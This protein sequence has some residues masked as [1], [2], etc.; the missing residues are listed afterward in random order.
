MSIEQQATDRV[1]KARGELILARRFY[2]VLVSNVEPVLSRQFPTMATNGKKHFFNPEFVM[3]LSKNHLGVVTSPAVLL[4]GVQAHESE[5]DARHHGTRRN[6]RDPK[7][8]NVACDYAINIDLIDEGFQLPEGALIDEKY[9]DMSA[10]DIYRTRE[11]DEEKEQPQQPPPPEDNEGDEEGDDGQQQKPD[12]DDSKPGDDSDSDDKSDDEGDADDDSDSSDSDSDDDSSD[13]DADGDGD[14]DAED[15]DAEGEGE[16]EGDAE[17]GDG[18]GDGSGDADGDADADD[19]GTGAGSSGDPGQCGEV[20]DSEC[21]EETDLAQEDIKWERNVRQAASMAKAAGQLPGHITR[22]IERANNPPREWRDELREFCEQGA[23]RT[24]TWNRPNRRFMGRGIVLPSTQKDGIS[25]AAFLIDTSGS[26]DEIALACVQNE[27]Q[28]MLD[29]GIIDEI[30]VVYG[31][32][33]VT[34]VDEFKTGDEIEFDPRGGGGTDMRP[35]FDFVREQ[36][37]DATLI[38][39]FT[40]LEFYADMGDEPDCAVMFAVHGYP[41]RVKELMLT[42]PWGAR[43]IDVGV[44]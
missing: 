42:P 11:L 37:D 3:G 26:C 18:S 28:A 25:K 30:V 36:H 13:G 24:E 32:T 34:R 23:L 38:I 40:D 9:R 29:D 6:G 8:W 15:G 17:D 5:H 31:D 27:A 10:E 19:E 39:N 35:L 4:L 22:E 1:M 33:R 20:L 16:G 12:S 2:G 43:A 41:D 7:K 44:H 21:D 14:A